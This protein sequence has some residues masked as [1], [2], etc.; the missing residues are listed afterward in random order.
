VMMMTITAGNKK[1]S[2]E[3][4]NTILNNTVMIQRH[5]R[6]EIGI[7]YDIME[8]GLVFFVI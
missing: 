2:K 1:S 8:L 6:S 3:K 5:D 7:N 4:T